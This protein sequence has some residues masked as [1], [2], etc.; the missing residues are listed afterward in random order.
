MELR[1]DGL[2]VL[3]LFTPY[4]PPCV[5]AICSTV[6]VVEADVQPIVAIGDLPHVLGKREWVDV[7]G[8]LTEVGDKVSAAWYNCDACGVNACIAWVF[9]GPALPLA[10]RNMGQSASM[11]WIQSWC[12]CSQ[13]C[14]W[15]ALSGHVEGDHRYSGCL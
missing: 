1:G 10:K 3:L 7:C 11:G 6:N 2:F 15:V 12:A 8:V 4:A 13:V 14:A 5:Y 9:T